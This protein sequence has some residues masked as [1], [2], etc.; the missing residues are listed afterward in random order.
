MAHTVSTQLDKGKAKEYNRDHNNRVPESINGKDHIDPFGI[1]E[2]WIDETVKDAYERIFGES[3]RRYNAWQT[4]KDRQYRSYLTEL[5]K[6]GR[7]QKLVHEMVVQIGN[8]YN[9]PDA[10]TGYKIFREFVDG[11]PERNPNL[12]LIGAYYHAD[13]QTPH[14][15]MDFIPV[16]HGYKRGQDIQAGFVKALREQGVQASKGNSHRTQ[17]VQSESQ[18]LESICRRY[19]LVIEQPKMKNAQHLATDL[20]K[21]KQAAKDAEL[22]AA[23]AQDD[24]MVS[25]EK[26]NQVVYDTS[27]MQDKY[28]E[29]YS[30]VEALTR[31][32]EETL[33]EIEK[34][35]HLKAELLNQKQLREKYDRLR[36]HCSKYT[37]GDRTVLQIFDDREDSLRMEI[38]DRELS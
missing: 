8:Q 34:L 35:E 27:V 17:W 29:L 21:K 16:A 26:Y 38:T 36:I 5:K 4:R 33:L 7:G 37:V 30:E 1:H 14:V 2:S 3:T 6:T 23:K 20:Y 10:K 32:K 25:Y 22:A 19:G 12:A 11:W 28:D 24:M 15:H 13:E 31:Q 18:T 9:A